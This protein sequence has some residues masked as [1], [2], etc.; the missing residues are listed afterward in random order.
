M[1]QLSLKAGL[2]QWRDKAKE[3]VQSK[4]KHLHMRDTFNPLHQ[5]DLTQIQKDSSLKSTCSS[6]KR[7]MGMSRAAQWLVS[8]SNGTA[9]PK[10][11]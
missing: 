10:K 4:I 2:K 5:K 11:K 1:T 3:A 9:S 6:R 7:D 8:T